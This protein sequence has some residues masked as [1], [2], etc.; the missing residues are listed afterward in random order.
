MDITISERKLSFTA[1]YDIATTDGEYYARKS[2]FSSF[3]GLFDDIGLRYPGGAT[4]ARIHGGFSPLRVKHE[5]SIRDGRVY[6]FR[7]EKL[8]K[9]VYICEGNGERYQLYCHRGLNFSIF[10]EDRQIAAA[11]KNR[12]VFGKGNRYEVQIDSD[13]DAIVIICMMLA[14]SS[15]DQEDDTTV[16]IDFGNIGPEGRR[17]N[18]DW[19][20]R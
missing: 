18:P 19:Q 5:F 11:T 4:L 13:A 2:L 6:H 16:T 10:R 1:E 3:F 17:Y 7:C 15:N 14:L 20:P 9:Q 12:V 8:M